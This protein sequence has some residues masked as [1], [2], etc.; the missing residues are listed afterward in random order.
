MGRKRRGKFAGKQKAYVHSYVYDGQVLKIKIITTIIFVIQSYFLPFFLVWPILPTH[1]TY[2][3]LLL[4]LITLKDTLTHSQ[5]VE[6]LWTRDRPSAEASTWQHIT[7]R[8]QTSL[9]PAGLEP[10]TPAREWPQTRSLNRMVPET[11]VMCKPAKLMSSGP[12]QHR[13]WEYPWG[14]KGGGSGAVRQGV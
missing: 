10:A 1:C 14:R 4:D 6:I 3:G 2:R 5:S 7:F 8:R 9:T 13:P 11:A 12:T